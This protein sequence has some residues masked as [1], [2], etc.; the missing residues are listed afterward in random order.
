MRG[1]VA[2]VRTTASGARSAASIRIARCE[3]SPIVVVER[4]PRSAPGRSPARHSASSTSRLP[5]PAI[6]AW[7]IS[8]AF[9]GAL[10]RATT[11]SSCSNV[12]VERV[13]AEPGLVGV[14][15]DRAEPARIAQVHR[16]PVGEAHAE[17]AP[18]VDVAVARVDERIAG[19]VAVDQH[20]PAHAEVHPEHGTV[21][22]GVEQQQ[23]PPP[24]GCDERSARTDA[25]RPPA[26]VSPRFRN[27]ASG[28]STAAISRSSARASMQLPRRFD[29]DDLGQAT[30]QTL[31]MA[32]R[33]APWASRA[34]L[35]RKPLV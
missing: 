20:P 32:P 29:L 17:A 12:S 25:C 7:F 6:R 9:T 3:P 8:T 13:G 1:E 19:G 35:A 11:A 22:V 26:G 27:Q 15:L 4:R 14:E 23:L 18:R 30:R 31:V 5:S 33:S 10:L 34:Y 16:A 28:A 2:G 21:A 24:P